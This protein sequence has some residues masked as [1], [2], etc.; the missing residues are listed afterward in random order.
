M[1]IGT[2]AL[3]LVDHS[4]PDPFAKGRR[5]R[6][7]M[8]QFWYPA[9][10]TG[11]RRAYY[12]PHGTASAVEQFTGLRHG[13]LHALRAHA[14]AAVPVAR[15]PHP[16]IL[17]DPGAG[18]PRGLYTLLV[19][20]LAARGYIV[21][22]LDHPHEAIAVEFPGGR[23]VPASFEVTP[24][25]AKKALAVRV[26]DIRFV[27][28]RLAVLNARGTFRGQ[29]DLRRIG[30]VGHSLGGAAAAAAMLVD[31]RLQAGVDLDGSVS[32]PVVQIGLRRPFMLVNASG[33]F[34]RDPSL[35]ALWTHLKGP[36]VN[37][38]LARS[39]HYTFSDL[40]AL[41]PQL[42]PLPAALQQLDIGTIP[43]PGA[44][45]AVRASLAAFFDRYLRSQPAPLL[46]DPSR[47]YSELH[48]LG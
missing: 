11:P 34:R 33:S 43:P 48:R 3:R 8:V 37:L 2:T 14:T 26:A 23:L 1:P 22:A 21:A 47:F 38:E 36:R 41:T 13:T 27:L 17:F 35:R 15:G 32:G 10:R 39:G 16:V 9:E 25:T 28:A 4:R 44:V 46:D 45:A 19:E 40:V 42:K 24:R 29:F 18:I 20:D 31:T 30:I 6:E 5:D 7:L 12:L